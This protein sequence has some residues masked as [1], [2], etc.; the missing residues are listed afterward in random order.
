MLHQAIREFPRLSACGQ[1]TI[2][3]LTVEWLDTDGAC[4]TCLVD[5]CGRLVGE[6][7]IAYGPSLFG[8][9]TE[10]TL[11]VVNKSKEP[12]VLCAARA[13]TRAGLTCPDVTRVRAVELATQPGVD[14][15]K[16]TVPLLE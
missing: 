6:A 3:C 2:L 8:P 15:R 14:M 10:L 11:A 1:E 7:A 9:A 12:E 5:A 13:M 4:P 16:D